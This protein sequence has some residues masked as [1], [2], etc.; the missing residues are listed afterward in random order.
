MVFGMRKKLIPVVASL[1]FLTACASNT[2]SEGAKGTAEGS[3]NSAKTVSVFTSLYPVEYLVQE[4]G[5]DKV[6]IN[7]LAPA[8]VEPHDLELSPQQV[9]T[10]PQADL[11]V[12]LKGF[13]SAVDKAADQNPPKHLLDIAPSANL[14]DADHDEHEHEGH[15]HEGTAEEHEH[16]GHDH[17]G[18]A[19]GHEHEGHEHEGTAE[20]HEHE[21]HHHDHDNLGFDP[22]FW[23]N[24]NNMSS[25]AKSITEELVKIDPQNQDYYQKNLQKLEAQMKDLSTLAIDKTKNCKHRTFVTTHEAFGY[26]AKLTNLEQEGLSGLDPEAAPSPARLAEISKLVKE[27]GLNTIFTEELVSPKVAETLSKDLGIK[28]EVLSPIETQS[29]EKE[30]YATMFTKDIDQLSKALECQ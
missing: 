19:E 20:E 1:F 2:P 28:T 29:E 3:G 15:D 25:V 10:L 30:N 24:P 5:G 11:L 7:S 27:R 9:A 4:I 18:T 22:H 21:G 6:K 17:E 26:L 14:V 8:G 13:Q 12:Y 16:E 23:L